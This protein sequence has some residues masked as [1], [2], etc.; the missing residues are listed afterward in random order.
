MSGYFKKIT[1][2]S[3]RNNELIK[4]LSRSIF[5]DINID[6]LDYK[7]NKQI[8]IERIA[9]HGSENDEKIM[10]MMYPIKIIKRC[11]INSD[12]LN[13]NTLQYYAFVLKV[14]ES[15]FKCYTRIPVQMSF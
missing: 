13:E 8:I 15:K 3:K 9:V 6:K 12:S 11:L 7:K 10:N 5:W 4:L 14:K 1:N 2:E